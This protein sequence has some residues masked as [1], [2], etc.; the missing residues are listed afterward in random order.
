MKLCDKCKKKGKTNNFKLSLGGW[1]YDH[2]KKSDWNFELCPECTT[3][4][5]VKLDKVAK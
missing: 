3:E 2:K 4:L 5:K 1:H